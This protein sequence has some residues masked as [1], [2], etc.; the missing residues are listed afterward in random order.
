MVHNFKKFDKSIVG[1]CLKEVKG[2]E[3]KDDYGK[4]PELSVKK[5][6]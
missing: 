2:K 1:K 5:K 4:V 3:Y 6:K